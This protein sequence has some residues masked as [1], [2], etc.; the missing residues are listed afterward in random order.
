FDLRELFRREQRLQNLDRD[1]A[2]LTAEVTVELHGGSIGAETH[3]STKN[4]HATHEDCRCSCSK[5]CQPSSAAQKEVQ[6][7]RKARHS[8]G[9]SATRKAYQRPLRTASFSEEEAAYRLAEERGSTP[10]ERPGFQSSPAFATVARS[11][12]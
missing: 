8:A 5:T 11:C 2:P 6:R 12:S 7:S 10:R 3:G 4:D 9:F 1:V